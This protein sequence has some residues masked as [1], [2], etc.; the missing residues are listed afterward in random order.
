[1]NGNKVYKGSALKAWFLSKPNIRRILI[2]SGDSFHIMNLDEIIDTDYYLITHKD[3]N[4]ITIEE[5]E[6]ITD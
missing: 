5:V 4:S 1:M 6:L 2:P 3:F